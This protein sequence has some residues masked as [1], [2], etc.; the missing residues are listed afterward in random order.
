LRSIDY[1]YV[2]T[3]PAVERSRPG[4]RV[5]FSRIPGGRWIVDRWS[6][7][8]PILAIGARRPDVPVVPGELRAPQPSEDLAAVKM[9]SG[10]V[11]EIR[12]GNDVLWQRG[13]VSVTVRVV[14]SATGAPMRGV[15]VRSA[16]STSAT[17]SDSG[18]AVRLD[19]LPP[20][21]LTVRLESADLASIGTPF[22]LTPIDVPTVND[23]TVTV[24]AASARA[25][26][27]ARCGSR[28]LEWGEG[29]L[30]GRVAAAGPSPVVVTWQ[31]TYTRLGGG[32]SVVVEEQRTVTPSA[33]GEFEVC[34]VPRDARVSLRRAG[35]ARDGVTVEF[36]RGAAA[37]FVVVP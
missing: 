36:R 17:A 7:R 2:N 5:E 29:L 11:A 37:A 8:Y 31:T 16:E 21:P 14:D 3:S 9:T 26:V 33:M 15:L 18:G 19:R 25:V 20:G 10:Q 6:I 24:R 12:R 22:L 28:S 4:G 30:R 32:E 23:A 27:T 34:G 35:G 13:R 1:Q